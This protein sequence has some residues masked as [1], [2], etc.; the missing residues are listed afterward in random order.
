MTA[1]NN[2]NGLSIFV[3]YTGLSQ[4]K[5]KTVTLDHQ[6]F[7]C[8]LFS[9]GALT[10]RDF[11]KNKLPLPQGG[12]QRPGVAIPPLGNHGCF[13]DILTGVTE[14]LFVSKSDLIIF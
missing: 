2:I 5:N 13:S 14:Q 3:L 11:P 12:F 9:Q 4:R 1:F 10:Y 8:P 6:V 7:F